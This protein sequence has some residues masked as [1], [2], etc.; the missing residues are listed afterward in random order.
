[1][2]KSVTIIGGITANEAT[3]QSYTSTLHVMLEPKSLQ[4]LAMKTIYSHQ[5]VLPWKHLPKMLIA[6]LGLP[7]TKA[8]KKEESD[9]W[10]QVN[11]M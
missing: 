10:G 11:Q 8:S 9:A 7:V 2:N 3:N 6:S 5:T 4:Q 1:M